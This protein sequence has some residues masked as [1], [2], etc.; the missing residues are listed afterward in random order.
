MIDS[1]LGYNHNYRIGAGEFFDMENMSSDYYP[2]LTPRDKRAKLISDENIRGILLTNNRLVYLAGNTL[3]YGAKTY[4]ITEYVEDPSDTSDQTLLRFGAYILVYPQNVYVNL[5]VEGDMGNAKSKLIAPVDTTI[6]YSMCDPEGNDYEN[7]SAGNEPP[8]DPTDGEYWLNTSPNA[9]G[10]NIWV[11]AMSMWQPVA[12]THIRVTIPGTDIASSFA[13]GDTVNLNSNL[14][15]INNGSTIQAINGDS[16]VVLGI[17][18]TGV[19]YTERTDNSWTLK[20]ERK[21]PEMDFVCVSGNRVWGCHYGMDDDGKY[22]NEIYASRLG[23]FKNF[24]TYDG[25]SN[26][27]YAVSVGEDGAWTGCV[28]YQGKPVFFKEN[29]IFRIYGSYPA[30]YQV[31]VNNCRGVQTGSHRS[32]AI[33]NEYLIYKSSMDIVIYDG[34][35][36]VSISKELGRERQY[37]E[38]AAGATMNKYYISMIDPLGKYYYFVYD[39]EHGLWEREDANTQFTEFTTS[40]SGQVYARNKKEIYG[41]GAN[42]NMAFLRKLPGEDFVKWWCET[43][44]IGYEFPDFKKPI[45]ISLRTFVPFNSEVQVWV[46]YDDGPFE[47]KAVVRGNAK[48]RTHVIAFKPLPC[49]HYKIKLKGHGFCRIISMTTTYDAEGGRYG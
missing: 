8:A 9:S 37:Y 11:E 22:L 44:D 14:K 25:L 40:E 16:F 21:I 36:P 47:E 5:N 30:E 49:D 48:T 31:V 24:Y 19:T 26:D 27:A 34:T 33:L 41:I 15:D 6:T 12:T 28:T 20:V 42:D 43:G 29:Y 7:I 38:A 17:I 10:L 13:V 1:W 35:N 4:D 18:P 46:S 32:I 45:D 2:L 23:D 3:H 39:I